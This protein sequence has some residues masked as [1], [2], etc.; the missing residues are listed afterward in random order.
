M[1]EVSLAPPATA[2]TD[3]VQAEAPA[4]ATVCVSCGAPGVRAY[5]AACGQPAY[6]GRFTLR[7]IFTRMVAGAFDLDRG[8]LF[9]AL[10]LSR[11]PGAAIATYVAGRTVRYA[12]PVK[13]Y[14]IVA[15][16]MTVVYISTGAAAASMGQFTAGGTS[17]EAV[18]TMGRYLNLIMAAGIPFIALASRLLFRR[19]GHNLAEHLIF[20][21]FVYGQQCLL[22]VAFA[23]AGW[24]AGADPNVMMLASTAVGQIY[25]AWAAAGFFRVR[26]FTA[27]WRSLVANFLGYTAFFLLV[28]LGVV[29]VAFG[30]FALSLLSG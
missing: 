12:N 10:E 16:V 25:Y 22:F 1:S 13:Y 6:E 23:L 3:P 20:N 5:C 15:A 8:V 17:Q 24:A 28:V 27:A 30:A 4:A 2:A 18:D 19:S 9:T 14:L 7:T 26:A 21:T 29:A 11:R